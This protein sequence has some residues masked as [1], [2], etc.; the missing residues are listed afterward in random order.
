MS[1]DQAWLEQAVTALADRPATGLDGTADL[2]IGKT[3]QI[4]VQVEDGRIV[5]SASGI[6]E[7]QFPFTKV[8]VESFVAGEMK[9]AVNYMRG[10]LKPTGSTAAILAV[11]DAMDAL[12]HH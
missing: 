3:V 2:L 9:L 12:A 8:Q 6:A 4:S 11:I 10:D 7:C 5:G 1:F